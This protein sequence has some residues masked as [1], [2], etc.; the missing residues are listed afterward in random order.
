MPHAEM[1]GRVGVPEVLS[2][3]RYCLSFDAK[4]R[5]RS[6]KKRTS[7]CRQLLERIP[8]AEG[9][10]SRRDGAVTLSPAGRAMEQR[11]SD[12]IWAVQGAC[13]RCPHF[14]QKQCPGVGFS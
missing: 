14:A 11:W 8:E 4:G 9:R 1:P 2:G 7:K 3:L 12:L 10:R 5:L 6:L 13:M